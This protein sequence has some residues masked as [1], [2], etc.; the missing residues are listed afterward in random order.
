MS[1]KITYLDPNEVQTDER[2]QVR[3]IAIYGDKSR[4]DEAE[5]LKAMRQRIYRVVDAGEHVDP[6]EV[7]KHGDEWLVFDGH[8]RLAVYQKI[9]EKKPVK[10]PVVV[11][12]HTLKQALALGYKVNTQHGVRISTSDTTKAAFRACVYSFGAIEK[13]QIIQQGISERTAQAI[14]QAASKLIKEAHILE[15]DDEN[16]VKRKVTQWCNKKAKQYARSGL[17][18]I[19]TDHLG[20]PSYKFVLKPK[21]TQELSEKAQIE[22]M[23][24]Q[25][26]KLAKLDEYIFLKAL[27]KVSRKTRMDLPVS[28]GRFEPKVDDSAPEEEDF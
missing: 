10:I 4:G 17:D 12:P 7:I 11:L 16:E 23:A 1:E 28:V 13:N 22:H 19:Q 24:N 2:L 5:S 6:I 25:I 18:S 14:R 9:A 15:S 21:P 20:F 8:N 3:S 26:E 27:S